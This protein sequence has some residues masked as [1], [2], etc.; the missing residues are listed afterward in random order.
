[1][2]GFYERLIKSESARCLVPKLIPRQEIVRNAEY[3][4]TWVGEEC[5]KKTLAEYDEHA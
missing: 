3:L 1:V 2:V 4:K 5:Y